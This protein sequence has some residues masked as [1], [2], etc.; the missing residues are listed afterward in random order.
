M[1]MANKLDAMDAGT[2]SSEETPTNVSDTE[3][4]RM[5]NAEAIEAQKKIALSMAMQYPNQTI[6]EEDV[7]K[8]FNRLYPHWV[9][10]D[11]EE[12]RQS[13]QTQTPTTAK[14]WLKRAGERIV[15]DAN[16]R[17]VGLGIKDV[18]DQY[19]DD[20]RK[21]EINGDTRRTQN[22]EDFSDI[23]NRTSEGEFW[24]GV[25]DDIEKVYKKSSGN[26][27]ITAL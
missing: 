12:M 3:P 26:L 17:G 10:T 27:S 7:V 23:I 13:S 8:E 11:L 5:T 9:N 25:G 19:S 20:I 16:D 15:E 24:K 21:M 2:Y 18:S 14:G 1:N 4:V 6:T 22:A